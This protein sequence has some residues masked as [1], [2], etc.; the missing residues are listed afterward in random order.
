MGTKS[1]S[2][3]RIGAW[4][5]EWTRENYPV[6]AQHGESP[7]HPTVVATGPSSPGT[8]PRPTKV[9]TSTSSPKDHPSL[10]P[11]STDPQRGSGLSL[12]RD[13]QGTGRRSWK[14]PPVGPLFG[15]VAAQTRASAPSSTERVAPEPPMSVC[16]HPGLTALTRMRLPRSSEARIRDRALRAVFETRYP[17]E[18]P[19]MSSR[20]ASPVETLTIRP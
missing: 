5:S 16:T 17:G 4:N 7:N 2:T 10:N 8:R 15:S 9:A 3:F 1:N 13:Y 6:A 14:K 19:P 11:R 12:S 20:A 18:P